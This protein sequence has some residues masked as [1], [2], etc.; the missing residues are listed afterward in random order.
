MY[1]DVTPHLAQY[2]MFEFR[3]CRIQFHNEVKCQAEFNKSFSFWYIY[4]D[5]PPEIILNY[6]INF[7]LW[8]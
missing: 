3:N 1:F 2:N 8:Y 6:L 4:F 7:R 5:T